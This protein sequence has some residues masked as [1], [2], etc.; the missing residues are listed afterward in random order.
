MFVF[1]K[2]TTRKTE[3]HLYNTLFYKK[4]KNNPNYQKYTRYRYVYEEQFKNK[5]KNIEALI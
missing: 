5:I 2:N 3:V 1:V 4:I